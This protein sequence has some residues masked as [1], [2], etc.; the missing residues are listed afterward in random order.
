VTVEQRAFLKSSLNYANEASFME[1]WRI[2]EKDWEQFQEN[3]MIGN[4]AL[5]TLSTDYVNFCQLPKHYILNSMATMIA[6]LRLVVAQMLEEK[7]DRLRGRIQYFTDKLYTADS[8]QSHT[9]TKS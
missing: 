4:C 3:G 6:E 1:S 2:L 8:P 7:N 5:R 9:H